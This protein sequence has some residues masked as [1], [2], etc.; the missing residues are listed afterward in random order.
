MEEQ[1]YLT[2]LSDALI[3]YGI[4][5]KDTPL[6]LE[7]LLYLLEFQL[8]YSSPEEDNEISRIKSLYNKIESLSLRKIST[9]V[10]FLYGMVRTIDDTF[11]F[12]IDYYSE[13]R[14]ASLEILSNDEARDDY[15]FWVTSWHPEK[16]LDEKYFLKSV[17]HALKIWKISSKAFRKELFYKI[18]YP[19]ISS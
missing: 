6:T 1:S 5:A 13:L 12:Y 15:M 2:L 11:Q 3:Q 16:V 9:E 7:R 10:F 14:Q 17:K 19:P 8:E 18:Y 4:K